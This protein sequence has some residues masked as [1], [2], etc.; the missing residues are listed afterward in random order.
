[1]ACAYLLL[2]HT[3]QIP[4]LLWEQGLHL[5]LFF[6]LTLSFMWSWWTMP[7]HATSQSQVRPCLL[8]PFPVWENQSYMKLSIKSHY[9]NQCY[10]MAM[11]FPSNLKS[12]ELTGCGYFL[13][14]FKQNSSKICVLIPRGQ[15]KCNTEKE[16]I[17]RQSLGKPF[18]PLCLVLKEVGA[19][20]L[21]ITS[22]TK[23]L[24][25]KGNKESANPS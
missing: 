22:C 21:T 16:R 18:L 23:F 24:P 8:P 1:M 2:F 9:G 11:F 10:H 6:S 17:I 19:C 4:E 14:L 5:Y 7:Q 13:L 15:G 12:M 3:L 25:P 20:Q